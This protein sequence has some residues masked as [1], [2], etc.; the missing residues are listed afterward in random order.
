[1]CVFVV[2][3]CCISFHCLKPAGMFPG[4][5]SLFCKLTFM[6][7]AQADILRP[8]ILYM[9]THVIPK[10]CTTDNTNMFWC[11]FLWSMNTELLG[12]T[13][14]SCWGVQTEQLCNSSV[15]F[16]VRECG[17]R[18]PPPPRKPTE[19]VCSSKL[20]ASIAKLWMNIISPKLP[21]T[22]KQTPYR[23]PLCVHPLPSEGETRDN[24]SLITQGKYL[25]AAHHSLG[26][27]GIPANTAKVA[28]VLFT[29]P[30]VDSSFSSKSPQQDE[31]KSDFQR[32]SLF[33][34]LWCHGSLHG[35]LFGSDMRG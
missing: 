17:E 6:P 30:L 3:Y 8:F 1:M 33:V 13:L 16:T 24:D 31:D 27:P 21:T 25:K 26:P 19:R 32:A 2:F 35:C 23:L 34:I 18:V 12:V 14:G 11:V 22:R 20:R 15:F 28:K 9:F 10:G 29:S 7:P 5:S 4:G